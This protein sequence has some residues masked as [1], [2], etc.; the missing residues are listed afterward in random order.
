MFTI[1]DKT[2][3]SLGLVLPESFQSCGTN[4][5]FLPPQNSP[6]NKLKRTSEMC[7]IKNQKHKH[8]VTPMDLVIICLAFLVFTVIFS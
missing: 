2:A 3:K 1:D 4:H 5:S 7:E 8:K 6:N